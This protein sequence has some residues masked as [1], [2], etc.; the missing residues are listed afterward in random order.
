MFA[1]LPWIPWVS[2]PSLY[3]LAGVQTSSISFVAREQDALGGF[4]N[5]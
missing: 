4:Q 3:P 1:S 5:S 2:Q